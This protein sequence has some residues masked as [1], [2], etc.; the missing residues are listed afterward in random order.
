MP[1]TLQPLL[2][3]AATNHLCAATACLCQVRAAHADDALLRARGGVQPRAHLRQHCARSLFQVLR[4]EGVP[5]AAQAHGR[6]ALRPA[7]ARPARA[8]GWQATTLTLC[9]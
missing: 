2:L 8:A 7:Q 6:H 9:D 5:A 1:R 3:E 4:A